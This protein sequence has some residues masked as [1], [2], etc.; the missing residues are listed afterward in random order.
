MRNASPCGAGQP[1][2]SP[3]SLS[4]G[5]TA[6]FTH[7]PVVRARIACRGIGLV[8]CG[9]LLD[10][11]AL[12]QFLLL[13]LP[14]SVCAEFLISFA[15]AAAI[16]ISAAV[17]SVERV[18]RFSVLVTHPSASAFHAAPAPWRRHARAA[19]SRKTSDDAV[20][21]A[22]AFLRRSLSISQGSGLASSAHFVAA[23]R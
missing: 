8:H 1:A 22:D 11:Q 20:Q 16:E 5:D 15:D 4:A 2:T 3:L 10:G 9:V 23:S 17:C 14:S 13:E 21:L 6:P 19:S 12:H 18:A 7:A